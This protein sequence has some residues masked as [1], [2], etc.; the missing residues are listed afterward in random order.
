M[1]NPLSNIFYPEGLDNEQFDR[2]LSSG[3]FR[4]SI[5]LHKAEVICANKGLY[6]PINIRIRLDNHK[7]SKSHRRLLRKN[8]ELFTY[9][10]GNL[11]IND[12]MESLYQDNKKNFSGFICDSVEELLLANGNT[13]PFNSRMINVYS[14][15]KLI[16]ASVFDVGKNSIASI[17]GL[18]D[19]EMRSRYLGIYTMLLE[20]EEAKRQGLEYYYPGYI[21]NS[22]SSLDYKLSLGDIEYR[23]KTDSWIKISKGKS[24][25]ETKDFILSKHESVNIQ[26][27]EK[28]KEIIEILESYG[29]VGES[30]TYPIFDII[31]V[32]LNG[33][34]NVRNPLLVRISENIFV[35]YDYVTESYRAF[36]ANFAFGPINKVLKEN[37]VYTG[38]GFYLDGFIGYGQIISISKSIENLAQGVKLY[39]ELIK[40]GSLIKINDSENG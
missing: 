7:F 22:E 38:S 1:R 25:K 30:L 19:L 35:E 21:F 2:Y 31:N 3:F 36:V 18:Y 40:Y 10:I 8:G 33:F 5:N 15:E 11:V 9:D 14:S 27:I 4:A 20:I 16:A 32:K 24:V 28:Q 6:S 39:Y 23:S 29:I 34:V 12:D 26:L 13:S 17:L 37:N